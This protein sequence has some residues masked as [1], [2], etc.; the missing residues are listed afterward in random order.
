MTCARIAR[1]IGSAAPAL[2]FALLPKCPA[3]LGASL[4]FAA[5]L[6][7]SAGVLRGFVMASFATALVLLA[8]VARRR[9]QMAAFAVACSGASIVA[10][11]R[12]LDL[13]LPVL[14]VGVVVLYG[15]A[16]RIYLTGRCSR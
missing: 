9:Q 13:G 12:W 3:C 6:G 16:L 4:A 5:S 2:A 10:L 8:I 1:P 11:G 14:V 15:A 7:I